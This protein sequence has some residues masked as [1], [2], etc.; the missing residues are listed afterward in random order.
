MLTYDDLIRDLYIDSEGELWAGTSEG[1]F[2]FSVEKDRFEDGSRSM[3]YRR[4]NNEPFNPIRKNLSIVSIFQHEPGKLLLG[5]EQGLFEFEVKDGDDFRSISS[6]TEEQTVFTKILRDKR[7][8]LWASSYDGLNYI[9]KRFNDKGYDVELY[10]DA[11]PHPYKLPVDWVEDFV[12]DRKGNMWLATRGGGLAL[13]VNN[14]I[15]EVYSFSNMENS[16]IPDNIINSLYIDRTG[17]LWIGTESKELVFLDLYA[18]KFRTILSEKHN[19][20]SDN[21]V[22]AITGNNNVLFAGTSTSEIGRAHV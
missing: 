7:G 10:N 5:A 15:E 20:V 14:K 9:K 8:Q 3:I 13:M 12:E 4:E 6:I 11:S 18:K 17:V 16:G 22:T 1:L 21:L 19:G 2:R